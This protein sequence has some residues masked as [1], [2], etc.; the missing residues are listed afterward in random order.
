MLLAAAQFLVLV[1]AAMARFGGGT[2]FDPSAEGYSFWNNSLSDLGRTISPS[3]RSS[4]T[5]AALY[6]TALFGLI[7]SFVP[8]FLALPALMPNCPR[9]GRLA[10]GA[11]LVSLAGMVGV[12]VTP[13]DVYPL[14][15]MVTIGL[16]AVPALAAASLCLTG[17]WRDRACPRF[18]ALA[19][20]IMLVS[21]VAHFSQYVH[22]FWLGGNWTPACTAAQ[23]V[24]AICV[25]GWVAL[26]GAALLGRFVPR[27][28]D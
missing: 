5:S 25:L 16:A 21:A 8:M 24:L 26:V 9:T 12:A 15:H 2:V 11:G 17:M 19:T 7:C 1:A 23:K 22:H 10:R 27:T 28:P 4:E 18:L 14:A 3:G 6:H 13:T 20:T